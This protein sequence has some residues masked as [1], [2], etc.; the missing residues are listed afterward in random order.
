MAVGV[1]ERVNLEA[2][3][4]VMNLYNVS[5][6]FAQ[7]RMTHPSL[8]TSG[9]VFGDHGL[10]RGVPYKEVWNVLF[11]DRQRWADHDPYYPGI[12][13]CP[14][15]CSRETLDPLEDPAELSTFCPGDLPP[16]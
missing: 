10:A 14:R 1:E 4:A 12:D 13:H 11:P 9:Y 15:H 5:A 6:D 16:S 3:I 8:A 2:T 7:R